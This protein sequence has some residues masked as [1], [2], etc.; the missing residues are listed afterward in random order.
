MLLA[1]QMRWL[2]ATGLSWRWASQPPSPCLYSAPPGLLPQSAAGD[3]AELE[4]DTTASDGSPPSHTYI[5]CA[6]LGCRGGSCASGDDP[7]HAWFPI[8]AG[9]AHHQARQGI[10]KRTEPAVLAPALP[11]RLSHLASYQG[12]GTAA[13]ECVSGCRC[14]RNVLDGTWERD[15]SLFTIMRFHVGAG[16]HV[17]VAFWLAAWFYRPLL[18]SVPGVFLL[19]PCMC[20]FPAACLAA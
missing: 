20:A 7:L 18:G 11:R 16:F 17:A 8:Q 1:N 6:Q 13:V 2:Q 19:R 4:V 12:M 5:W 15:A 10:R 14:K 3:W 9:L